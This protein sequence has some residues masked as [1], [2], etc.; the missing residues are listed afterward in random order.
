M[1]RRQLLTGLLMTIAM[2]VLVGLVYPLVV[3]GVA[4]VAMSTTRP[5]AR[6]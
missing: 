1:M 2:I 5:T 3:T 6:S 4:Q